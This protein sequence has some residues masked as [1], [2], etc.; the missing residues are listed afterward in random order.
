MNQEAIVRKKANRKHAKK[1]LTIHEI[2]PEWSHILP[3]I[4]KTGNSQF[5]KNGKKLDISD[6]KYCVVGEA[7]GF[8]DDY[9]HNGNK[10][11]C[12]PCYSCA[13]NLGYALLLPQAEREGLVNTFVDHWNSTHL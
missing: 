13:I 11:F 10:D 1:E 2:S 5:Y 9:S 7:Y 3:L 12:Y 4:P 8:K 6:C